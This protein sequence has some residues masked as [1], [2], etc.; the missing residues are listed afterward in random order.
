V[1]VVA[2]SAVTI[3]ARRA[4]DPDPPTVAA[5]ASPFVDVGSVD[6][7]PPGSDAILEAPGIFVLRTSD[8]MI[9]AF[10]W[11]A[12][13]E[14]CRI[15]LASELAPWLDDRLVFHDPCHGQN[16]DRDGRPAGGPG[17]R[18]MYRCDVSTDTGRIVVDT[19]LARPGPF[20]DSIEGGEMSLDRLGV[21]DGLALRWRDALASAGSAVRGGGP[22]PFVW[23]LGAFHDVS[24]DVVSAAFTI[25]GVAGEIQ[26]G[27]AGSWPEPALSEP[28]RFDLGAGTLLV[29][30]SDDGSVL[31]GDMAM[32]DGRRLRL[33][34]LIPICVRCAPPGPVE[35]RTAE[36]VALIDHTTRAPLDS[37]TTP[38]GTAVVIDGRMRDG[39]P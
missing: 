10:S 1:I 31:Q 38:P 17:I 36:V 26:I 11:R 23:I 8:G 27:P 30:M 35:V 22:S 3:A 33:G 2:A 28:V 24:T 21:V 9:T 13:K 32:T 39:S 14:G 5:P 6:R 7:L 18:G 34:V 4:D 25:D 20:V 29:S 16:F 19:S 12:P 15:A 37:L